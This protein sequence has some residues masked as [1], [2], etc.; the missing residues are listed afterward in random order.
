MS[1]KGNDAGEGRRA[2]ATLLV[3]P[4][5][6]RGAPAEGVARR[7]RGRR[8]AGA[9]GGKRA[10]KRSPLGTRF[11]TD[12]ARS[13]AALAGPEPAR[14]LQLSATIWAIDGPRKRFS[15]PLGRVRGED[16]DNG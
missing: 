11:L 3:D 6:K 15:L 8:T 7:T 2:P 1:A 13:P 14:S 5:A 10:C 16:L 4:R 9:G 12:S